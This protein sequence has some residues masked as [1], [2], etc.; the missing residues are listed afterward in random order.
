MNVLIVS[1]KS[2]IK[3]YEN[4]VKAAPNTS[5]LGA[6]TTLNNNFITEIKEKYHPH[7][8]LVDTSVPAKKTSVYDVISAVNS[9]YPYIKI[10]VLTD[11]DD[12]ADYPAFAVIRG[13]ITNVEFNNIIKQAQDD[14]ENADFQLLSDKTDSNKLEEVHTNAAADFEGT[15]KTTKLYPPSSNNNVDNLS[16]LKIKIPNIKPNKRKKGYTRDD[17]TPIIIAVTAVAVIVVVTTILLCIKSCNSNT[18]VATNDEVSESAAT[19]IST[20]YPLPTEEEMIVSFTDSP[21]SPTVENAEATLSNKTSEK[22]ESEKPKADT[23]KENSSP[24][25][26]SSSKS[27]STSSKTSSSSS[28]SKTSSN[29]SQSS[30]KSEASISYDNDRYNNSGNDDVSSIRLSYNSKTL[31]VDDYINLKATTY[32]I[33]KSVSWS[34]NNTYVATV[35]SSGKVTAKNTGTAIITASVDGIKAKCTITVNP[36]PTAAPT[37][38]GPV[39]LSA[40]TQKIVVGQIINITLDRSSGCSW[41]ISNPSIVQICGGGS[42]K[43]TVKGIKS[44]NTTITATNNA[45]GNTY[46]CKITVN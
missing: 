39:K 26:S 36:K 44:G 28:S 9:M 42:N 30:N 32:P 35:N 31:R 43:I 24:K 41:K 37:T 14:I 17:K 15:G 18:I 1:E 46:T 2:E 8:L 23:N 27:S 25:S 22:S 38:K 45:T 4:I 33:T 40:A 3:N 13:Q 6:V 12:K 10:I 16:N 11:E 20:T 29:S 5:V 21:S 7:A 34:S 19:M